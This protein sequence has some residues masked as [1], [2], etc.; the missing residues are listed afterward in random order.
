MKKLLII[1]V[2]WLPI[3]FAE[4]LQFLGH[5]YESYYLPLIK[6]SNY[7]QLDIPQKYGQ[8][9]SES[10]VITYSA[11]KLLRYYRNIVCDGIYS[12]NCQRNLENLS[13]YAKLN[14]ESPPNLFAANIESVIGYKIEYSAIG[15][16]N[17]SHKL[18][19]AML[20]PQPLSQLKGI[21]L[22]YHYTILDKRNIPSRFNQDNFLLS[23]QLAAA[24]ASSG[25]LVLAPDYPGFGSDESNIHPYVN[26]PAAN[27]LS[28]IYLLKAALQSPLIKPLL[29]STQSGGQTNSQLPLFISGYSEGGSYALWT[30]K[31]L[32]DNPNFLPQQNLYLAKSIPVVGAYNLSQI[33]YPFMFANINQDKTLPYNVNNYWITAFAKPGFFADSINGYLKYVSP[34]SITSFYN[35]LFYDCT[36]CY[37]SNGTTTVAQF[38][39]SIGINDGAMYEILVDQAKELDYGLSNNSVSLIAAA[40]LESNLIFKQQFIAADIYNWYIK[41]PVTFLAF[42]YDSI[43]PTIN[44]ETAFLATAAQGSPGVKLL[45]IPNQD[46]MVPGIIPFSDMEVDHPYGIKFMLAFIRQEIESYINKN[47]QNNE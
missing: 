28:G 39:E 16:D 13:N 15:A 30:T 4:N 41:T 10:Q 12:H 34:E 27:A 43:V 14:L 42:E 36:H 18:S 45:L 25:Y 35:P 37:H 8:L 21:I 47:H 11:G 23:P 7:S 44:S 5:D 33:M 40:D 29:P 24:L 9:Y 31:F 1:L 26:F 6:P 32:Q 20:L 22:F 46:F 19:G 17:Q 2:W 38:M 3:A